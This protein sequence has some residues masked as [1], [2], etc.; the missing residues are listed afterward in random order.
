[1]PIRPTYLA[2]R[3]T[4]QRGQLAHSA[5]PAKVSLNLFCTHTSKIEVKYGLMVDVWA[6]PNIVQSLKSSNNAHFFFSFFFSRDW[7]LVGL[8][9]FDTASKFNT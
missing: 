8:S 7:Q 6:S 4:C 3:Y 5:Q 1:M 2:H 9:I